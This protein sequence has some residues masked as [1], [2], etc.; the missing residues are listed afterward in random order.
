M[1]PCVARHLKVVAAEQ[2]GDDIHTYIYIY[3]YLEVVA[4]EHNGDDV[5]A[6][7]VHVTLHG[8]DDDGALALL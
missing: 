3:I 5:L 7:V 2:N 1:N 4:A 6:D 8:G